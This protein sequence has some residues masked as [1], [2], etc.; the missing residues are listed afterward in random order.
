MLIE[1]EILRERYE[2]RRKAIM[3]HIS[4]MED[5]DEAVRKVQE[6][7]EAAVREVQEAAREIQEAAQNVQDVAREAREIAR[8]G[9][10]KNAGRK[11]DQQHPILRTVD[12]QVGNALGSACDSFTE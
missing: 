2:A 9:P 12:W 1:A 3:D 8:G 7:R 10:R 4:F 6:A 5:A 11:P